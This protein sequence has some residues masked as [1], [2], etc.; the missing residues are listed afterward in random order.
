MSQFENVLLD[1]FNMMPDYSITALFIDTDNYFEAI[2]NILFHSTE[3]REM[4]GAYITITRP[5]RAIMNKLLA[6]KIRI[7]DMYFIDC[8]SYTVGGRSLPSKQVVNLESPTMLETILLKVDWAFRQIA[9]PHKFVFLDSVNALA[10]YNR[11]KIL[12]EFLHVFI[13]KL[14]ERDIFSIM[15]GVGRGL[16]KDLEEMLQLTCDETVDMR[17]SI[18]R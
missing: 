14:R 15:L 4:G 8:I 11:E 13:N 5:A 2:M 1:Q 18:I 17:K 6:K 12:K 7:A 9:S 3:Q 16:P 10:I